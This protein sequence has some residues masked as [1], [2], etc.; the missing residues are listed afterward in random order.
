MPAELSGICCDCCPV[1]IQNFQDIV[2]LMPL[3]AVVL[4]GPGRV[5]SRQ[6]PLYMGWPRI[7]FAFCILSGAKQAAVVFAEGKPISRGSAPEV[8]CGS[9]TCGTSGPSPIASG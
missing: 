3:W 2:V 8:P 4:H 7:P 9:S 1:L 5:H 6:F